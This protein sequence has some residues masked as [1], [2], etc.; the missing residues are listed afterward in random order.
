MSE[1]VRPVK[2]GDVVT[3]ID[4]YRQ[5]RP[6]LVTCVFGP[7]CLNIVYVSNDPARTDSY[8]QQIERR[9]SVLHAGAYGGGTV[10]GNVWK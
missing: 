4:E 1:E 6:A 5:E 7:T 2:I 3:F 8:G 9:T 10:Y